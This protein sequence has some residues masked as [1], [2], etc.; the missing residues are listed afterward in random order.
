MAAQRL[1]PIWLTDEIWLC[2]SHMTFVRLP[3]SAG[4]CWYAR[5]SSR[6]PRSQRLRKS[7][8]SEA[9]RESTAPRQVPAV[10]EC[11]WKSCDKEARPRSKYCSRE[12]SNKN[13][14]SRYNSSKSK[15]RSAA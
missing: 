12:C 7:E 8:L 5:C 13:A 3:A 10:N 2:R 6:P 4:R 11:A 15:S 9:V 1:E 14:R